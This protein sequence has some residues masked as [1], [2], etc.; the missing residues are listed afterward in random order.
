MSF[1]TCTFLPTSYF[2]NFIRGQCGAKNIQIHHWSVE[3]VIIP[4]T[5]VC[6][7]V[8]LTRK[9]VKLSPRSKRSAT[10]YGAVSVKVDIT[11]HVVPGD[12]KVRPGIKWKFSTFKVPPFSNVVAMARKVQPFTMDGKLKLPWMTPI[13]IDCLKSIGPRLFYPA[14]NGKT[15]AV[16]MNCWGSSEW[17]LNKMRSRA[18]W[19]PS[20]DKN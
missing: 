13:V 19:T 3:L 7:P 2:G 11:C 18:A 6:N 15:P 8:R 14:A 5:V 20:F 10:H 4:V 12:C 16:K 1:K 17:M 9:C